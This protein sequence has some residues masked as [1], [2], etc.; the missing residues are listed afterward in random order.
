MTHEDPIALTRQWLERAVIGLNLC[1]FAKAVY[2]RQQVRMVASAAR[3]TDQLLQA[4]DDELVFLRDADPVRTDTTL[5]IHPHVLNDFLEYNDFLD[6]ADL[7]VA[8]LG[9]RG[10]IQI[11]SFHPDYQFAGTAVDDIGNYS[12]R[13]PFP[14]LHLLREASVARAVDAFPDPAAIVGRN[15]VTLTV[16]GHE[17]W[18]RLLNPED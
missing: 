6:V 8:A 10:T 9:L 12:N 17:G 1:P 5:L 15:L 13:A 7:A 16:L 14:M 11:A 2:T 3:S 4:L 18:K